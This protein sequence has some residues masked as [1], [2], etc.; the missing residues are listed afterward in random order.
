[1][2]GFGVWLRMDNPTRIPPWR[3][4]VV[5]EQHSRGGRGGEFDALWYRISIAQV[6]ATVRIAPPAA[7]EP[8][9]PP[10][11]PSPPSE[12][13]DQGGDDVQDRAGSGR[14]VPGQA[15][16]STEPPSATQGHPAGSSSASA[17]TPVRHAGIQTARSVNRRSQSRAGG[18]GSSGV[19]GAV[20]LAN[21]ASPTGLESV[22]GPV[23]EGHVEASEV[24]SPVLSVES[25]AE[26]RTALTSPRS[27]CATGQGE[28]RLPSPE[29]S[30]GSI[31]QSRDDS[32]TFGIR[33]DRDQDGRN[34]SNNTTPLLDR[35]QEDSGQIRVG[36]WAIS[37]PS[38]SPAE[39]RTGSL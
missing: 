29:S 5:E 25:R 16:R 8:P 18:P 3:I 15:R 32:S 17:P 9:P 4:L 14:Q 24:S 22:D 6:G 39:E 10:P 23:V 2:A 26:P 30:P 31:N 36:A 13:E 35:G 34:N 38:G 1:M 12:D 28:P 19:A 27:M 11:P 21:S 37:L 20:V 33:G 7:A